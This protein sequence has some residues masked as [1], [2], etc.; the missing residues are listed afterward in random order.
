MND[1]ASKSCACGRFIHSFNRS[2]SVPFRR[3]HFTSSSLF[4]SFI[5]PA[6]APHSKSPAFVPL[7]KSLP[8]PFRVLVIC[9]SFSIQNR[10]PIC[11]NHPFLVVCFNSFPANSSNPSIS[12][13]SICSVPQSHSIS[14]SPSHKLYYALFSLRY[15]PPQKNK[16]KN[17]SIF[18]II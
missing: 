12:S 5:P 17:Q 9:L 2:S 18:L 8:I 13:S 7:H 14:F 11:V 16:K 3:L 10:I 15:C 1:S 4:H 6:S